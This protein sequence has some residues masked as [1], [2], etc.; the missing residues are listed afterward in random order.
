[1]AGAGF[2]EGM[3]TP[4]ADAASRLPTLRQMPLPYI[5]YELGPLEGNE[6]QTQRILGIGRRT[7]YR[8]LAT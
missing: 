5:R 3:T 7:V 4:E 2:R 1:M 6:R 8:Y